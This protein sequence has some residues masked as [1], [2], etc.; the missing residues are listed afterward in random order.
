MSSNYLG[1]FIE[2]TLF[3]N[4]DE[5]NHKTIGKK[6]FT[7]FLKGFITNND[8]ITAEQK[9]KNLEG[10]TKIFAQTILFSN[11]E[12]PIEIEQNDRRFTVFTTG[13]SLISN[14]FLGYG[15]YKNLQSAINDEIPDFVRFLKQMNVDARMVNTIF[16]TP[17]QNIMIN[18]SLDNLPAFIQAI[19]ALNIVFFNDIYYEN[20]QLYTEIQNDFTQGRINRANIAKAYN[21][22]YPVKHTSSKELLSK[23][24]MYS[25]LFLD[26]NISHSGSKHYYRLTVASPS[27]VPTPS[28]PALVFG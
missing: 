28:A 17:E 27:F 6:S 4:F 3:I 24:R 22:L 21:A 14:D 10:A 26:S 15:S 20:M 9:N 18:A 25:N 5:I 16:D 2:D 23:I 7:S 12:F 1:S 11:D 13:G 8:E 19:L